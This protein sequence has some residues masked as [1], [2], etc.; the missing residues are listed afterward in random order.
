[1]IQVEYTRQGSALEATITLPS[2]L[3]GEFLFNGRRWTLKPGL[4]HIQA[5]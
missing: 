2:R 3:S 5:P 4:N 1:M